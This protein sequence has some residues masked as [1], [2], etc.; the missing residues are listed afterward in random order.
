ML[1]PP[2][3]P[4]LVTGNDSRD[5]ENA[6]L[7]RYLMQ[8]PN[9]YI[10]GGLLKHI[11][12]PTVHPDYTDLDLIA[13]DIGELDRIQDAFGYVFRELPRIGNG[14]RYFIGKSRGCDKVIQL[15][16]MRSHLH[17]LQ[18]AVEGP[19]YDVDR[20][21]FSNGCFHFDPAIGEEAISRAIKTR[22]ASRVT[23]P[24]NMAHFAQHRPQIEQRHRLKLLRKG[25]TIIG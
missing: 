23:T 25:F 6:R 9:L 12:C 16:L 19:Q 5:L 3:E 22:K 7:L 11:I 18:F 2:V 1:L 21:V 13:I 17:A 4:T 15:I 8:A 10:F 24:R 14:P 20:V